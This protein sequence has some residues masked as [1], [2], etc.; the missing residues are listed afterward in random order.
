HGT[1]KSNFEWG[2]SAI[3]A[4]PLNAS[5]QH[6]N[7]SS[8]EPVRIFTGTTCPRMV[9]IIHNDDYIFRNPFNFPDRFHDSSDD[10]L[11]HKHMTDRY[12]DTNL[13]P[14]VNQFHLDYLP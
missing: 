8:A 2:P 1:S 6:F 11:C 14:A 4:I 13:F 5:Y 10:L 12:L 9:N 3:F 7:G